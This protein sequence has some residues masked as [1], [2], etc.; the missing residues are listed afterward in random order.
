MAFQCVI[1]ALTWRLAGPRVHGC[2]HD[3][4]LYPPVARSPPSGLRRLSESDTARAP[5]RLHFHTNTL[6]GDAFT[7]YEAGSSVHM[8]AGVV[9]GYSGPYT[10]GEDDVLDAG[11]RAFLTGVIL[12][13]IS[14]WLAA[15][16]RIRAP[17]GEALTMTAET[18]GFGS[19]VVVPDV[20]R[21]VGVHADMIILVTARPLE[22]H[23]VAYGGYCEEDGGREEPYAP[24]RPL[25]GHVN[26]DPQ[27]LTRG[28]RS[29]SAEEGPAVDW[30]LM[31]MLHEVTHALGFRESKIRQ[32]PCPEN[33][34]FNRLTVNVTRVDNGT[35]VTEEV[36]EDCPEGTLNPVRDEVY[37]EE[38]PGR[39]TKV[40]TPTVVQAFRAHLSCSMAPGQEAGGL[41]SLCPS[42]DVECVDGLELENGA[43]WGDMSVS[44]HWEER[45]VGDEYMSPAVVQLAKSSVLTL[46][47]FADSGWFDVDMDVRPPTCFIGAH[48]AEP[49]VDAILFACAEG[50]QPKFSWGQGLGCSFAA[51]PCHT[52][53]AWR[54]AGYFCT[55]A[56]ADG[57]TEDRHAVGGCTLRDHATS[58]PPR[59]QYFAGQ[60][61]RGGTL[62]MDYC[63]MIESYLNYDCR[64]AHG[65]EKPFVDDK[66]VR[67]GERRSVASRC[68]QSSVTA[69]GAEP[70]APG[71]YRF[72][73][74]EQVRACVPRLGPQF[75]PR[76]PPR[77]RARPPGPLTQ[78]CLAPGPA[79]V[80]SDAGR[81]LHVKVGSLIL[82][83][84]PEGGNVSVGVDWEGHIFCPRAVDA[85]ADAVRE[86]N[87]PGIVSIEPMA[88]P[89][90]GGTLVTVY[91][92]RLTGTGAPGTGP[93]PRVLLG[94]KLAQ[95]V[96][97]A[98]D[99]TSLVIM[100]P[101]LAGGNASDEEGIGADGAGPRAV[102][103]A[104]TDP[105]GRTAYLHDAFV[106]E[107]SSS[108][109]VV[110]SGPATL[111]AL[112]AFMIAFPTVVTFGVVVVTLN[113]WVRWVAIRHAL[114]RGKIAQAAA[115]ANGDSTWARPRLWRSFRRRAPSPKSGG[116]SPLEG[117]PS[118]PSPRARRTSS[119]LADS[120]GPSGA[121][122]WQDTSPP[123][124]EAAAVPDSVHTSARRPGKSRPVALGGM[125][126][127][128]QSTA[129]LVL[130]QQ[131]PHGGWGRMPP[132][133][134]SPEWRPAPTRRFARDSAASDTP[135]CGAVELSA[136]GAEWAPTQVA[137][138]TSARE[139][140]GRTQEGTQRR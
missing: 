69:K 2:V 64:S 123:G 65:A 114:R 74:Y 6:D 125:R 140:E 11:K 111:E 137:P 124:L 130:A 78:P 139:G 91:G 37:S 38:P 46:A 61:G 5:L 57:C 133:P 59:F 82:R 32:F 80:C 14:R 86:G 112:E 31:T 49:A 23:T 25:A 101:A 47:L 128:R 52:T 30:L 29:G 71:F 4:L 73:C 51:A 39:I 8:A 105:H 103:V 129:P 15:A 104:V 92:Q 96:S 13:A 102:S 79:Q 56:G 131:P 1:H 58:L 115:L 117:L 35:E 22:G 113:A 116:E 44:S 110:V 40:H 75:A 135:C 85:C 55:E 50:L 45:L 70:F 9:G 76:M 28:G 43:G 10:C 109:G 62:F 97:A 24:P 134:T 18:C 88:G 118:Q 136:V 119:T 138:D 36:I 19:G 122:H 67:F 20:L 120:P 66:A 21:T 90:A 7:C 100:T 94:A 60:P 77:A 84:P 121:V 53:A 34:G 63:P 106:Y 83:C 87:W 41:A 68:V 132:S 42:G 108:F 12:P 17:V 27:W 89:R 26:I 93:G 127:K 95:V 72:G 98:A 16:L 48:S 81:Q 54:G 3:H 33:P 99:G 126:G 107:D